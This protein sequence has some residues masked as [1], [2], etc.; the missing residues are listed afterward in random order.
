MSDPNNNVWPDRLMLRD[1][2]IIP[3]SG[4]GRIY[5]TTGFGYVK[6]PYVREV[7]VERKDAE[8]AKLLVDSGLAI[9]EMTRHILKQRAEIER[10]TSQLDD[11][12]DK[13]SCEICYN[14]EVR[15]KN[16]LLS[17]KIES[18]YAELEQAYIVRERSKKYL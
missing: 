14:A 16:E 1:T 4:E 15:D 7:L 6:E 11:L 10:L 18:L 12:Q 2:Q 8:R 13:L 9:G 3:D 17:K 5:T